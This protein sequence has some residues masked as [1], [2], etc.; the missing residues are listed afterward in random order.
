MFSAVNYSIAVIDCKVM[1]K[2]NNACTA[3][4]L[5]L[6]SRLRLAVQRRR[7]VPCEIIHHDVKGD[8]EL[9]SNSAVNHR[10]SRVSGTFAL[11]PP[12]N[13]SLGRVHY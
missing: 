9:L 4:L 5:R 12:S 1:G 13:N 11:F 10:H 3:A 6:R 8:P 7:R 2:L